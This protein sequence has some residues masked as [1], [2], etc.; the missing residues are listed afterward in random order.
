MNPILTSIL[1]GLTAAAANVFGTHR[2]ADLLAEQ[3]ESG[4]EKL[5]HD[6][7]TALNH[8]KSR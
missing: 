3:R 1:L 8:D 7:E 5:C 4:G 6:R 2:I